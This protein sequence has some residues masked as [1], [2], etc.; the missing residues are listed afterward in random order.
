MQPP[1]SN[2]EL[3]NG[4]WIHA[5]YINHSCLPNT[6]RT[7]IGDVHF[8]RATR[9]IEAGEELTHQYISPEIDIDDRQKKYSGTWGFRCDCKLC[10]VDGSVPE[11]R[12]KKRLQNFEDLKNLVMKLGERGTTITSLKKIAR[13]LRE[14]EAL[15]SGQDEEE[16]YARIPRLGL[17]HPT[18]F[19]TEAWRGVGNLDRTVEYARKL[20]RNFG[21]LTDV[22]GGRFRVTSNSGF[23]NVEGVRAL[24]YLAEGYRKKGENDLAD[25]CM[26]IAKVWFLIITGS[27]VGADAFFAS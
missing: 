18:L 3:R 17:V 27:E 15:Y 16:R 12:R 21:V 14:L 19:L 5:S 4:F 7:F 2:P 11:E 6:V 20:L 22:E 8:L 25:Q 1:N 23:I 10:E 13:G 26:E 24:K 9:D